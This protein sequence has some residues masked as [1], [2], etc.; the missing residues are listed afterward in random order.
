LSG[1]PLP[2]PLQRRGSKKPLLI[3][4]KGK[5]KKEEILKLINKTKY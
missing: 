5:N 1:R 3:P 4:Q 2:G